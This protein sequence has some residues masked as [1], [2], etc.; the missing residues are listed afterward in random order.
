MWAQP[1]I[2]VIGHSYWLLSRFNH[3]F[4]AIQQEKWIQAQ[5]YLL[6]W[7]QR[8]ILVIGHSCWLLSRFNHCL[9]AI[10]Q[11][12][13]IQAQR[14]LLMWAQPHILINSINQVVIWYLNP[15]RLLK[16]PLFYKAKTDK[17]QL[18]QYVVERCF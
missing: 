5:R 12:K 13:W 10:Q 15:P 1:H 16:I 17:L 4:D 8:Y 9:D 6:M 2:L 3:C 18:N 7:A 11:E 14:Y